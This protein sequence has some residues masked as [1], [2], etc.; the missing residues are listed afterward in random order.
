MRKLFWLLAV[1]LTAP[2]W[3]GVL[4]T[5]LFKGMQDELTRTQQKLH[6]KN[7]PRPFFTAYK[8]QQTRAENYLA[9]LGELVLAPKGEIRPVLTPYVHMVTGTAKENS[10]GF[11]N[12]G[13]YFWPSWSGPAPDS[14]DGV[15]NYF[16]YL[17][18]TDYTQ[19]LDT[20]AQKEAYKRQKQIR[21]DAPD[22]VSAPKASFYEDVADETGNR[23]YYENLVRRLSALGRKYKH[24]EK[25]TAGVSVAQNVIRYV[26][27]GGSWYQ[28]GGTFVDVTLA[29]QTRN[30]DG[31]KTQPSVTY[32]YTPQTLPSLEELEKKAEAFFGG[33]DRAYGAKKAE[34][35][36]GPVLLKGRASADFLETLFVQNVRHAKPLLT[37]EGEDR[38]AGAFKDKIGLR[39]ISHLFDV[40]DRPILRE[41]K[42]ERLLGF[43]PVDDEGVAAQNL[44]LVKNG[45]LLTL[46]STRNLRK[47]EKASNGHA[48]MS[49]YS[50]PR[51]ALTS[52]FFTPKQALSPDEM[53][54]KLLDRCRELDLE[55]CYVVAGWEGNRPGRLSGVFAHKIYV[56]DGRKEPVYGAR[57]QNLTPR[58]LRDISAAGS[59]EQVFNYYDDDMIPRTLVAPSLLV[60]EMEI[61]PDALQPDRAPFVKQPR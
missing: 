53:E 43:M 47:G 21:R 17:S 41:Y 50:R 30:K 27:S 8:L 38:S 51:S 1:C 7:Y 40:Q 24:A 36:L 46:P 14:Y 28:T 6:L 42:G 22:F 10:N 15:R 9:S 34:P 3:A 39:V 48:R 59:D 16:W 58:S 33:I 19:S 35:Y 61:V 18:N 12:P 11:D 26:D 54:Q 25:A 49:R 56:K 37:P 31:Y 4:Q 45:K 2:A 23:A 57:L 55:Y 29:A 52:V 32:T 60:E 5:D 13:Y 44:E 20:Y